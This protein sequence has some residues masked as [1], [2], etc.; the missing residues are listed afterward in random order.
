MAAV[1]CSPPSASSTFH[2]DESNN[3]RTATL[4]NSLLDGLQAG[5]S[6]LMDAIANGF[7]DKANTS[8]DPAGTF[9]WLVDEE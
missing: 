8:A 4:M 3:T 7:E 5:W 9:F 1:A 2:L 6:D